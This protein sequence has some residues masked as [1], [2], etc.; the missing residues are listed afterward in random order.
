MKAIGYVRVSTQEQAE[1]GL[2]LAAQD[3]AVRTYADLR[4]L[5][6]VAVIRDE[7]VSAGKHLITRAGGGQLLQRSTGRRPEVL[8]V[9]ALKLDRLFRSA[10]DALETVETWDRWDVSL[11]LVDQGGTSI[12]TGTAAGKFML[13]M[14]AGAAEMERNLTR[15]RTVAALGM[16]RERGEKT[17]GTVPFGFDAKPGPGGVVMLWNNAAEQAV[18]RRMERERKA[19]ATFRAICEQLN[20]DGVPTK[21]G[22]PW[23]PNTVRRILILALAVDDEEG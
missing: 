5:E 16:K 12:D 20:G 21:T 19:G 17:G 18:I 9:V 10:R 15:E 14:L 8:A 3:R 13:T 2:G 22:R 4:G 7:G 23:H 6:L 11:H 1:S